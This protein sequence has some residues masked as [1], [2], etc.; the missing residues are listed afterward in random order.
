MFRDWMGGSSVEV[1]TV[2]ELLDDRVL[3]D[4]RDIF[5]PNNVDK[6]QR[7]WG[8]PTEQELIEQQ[9]LPG[10]PMGWL[11]DTPNHS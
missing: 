2:S 5:Y 7:L 1:L 3:K 4:L 9:H 6:L 11:M 8:H 10:P